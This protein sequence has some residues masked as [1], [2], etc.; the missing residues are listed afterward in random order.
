MLPPRKQWESNGEEHGPDGG[1]G[2][3][4]RG[5]GAGTSR[6]R[7]HRWQ[8]RRSRAPPGRRS[9]PRQM[10]PGSPG[11]CLGLPRHPRGLSA[12]SPAGG[13]PGSSGARAAAGPSRHW[14]LPLPRGLG[15]APVRFEGRALPRPAPTPG[16]EQR[17]DPRK[18]RAPRSL[19]RRPATVVPRGR[20]RRRRRPGGRERPRME[21]EIARDNNPGPARVGSLPAGRPVSGKFPR[22][23]LS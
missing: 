16:A 5:A 23:D 19:L 15:C 4:Q 6:R 12:P 18:T 11:G 7:C 9:L 13:V 10:L 17:P 2:C 8:G 3:R 21:K 14:H 1:S 20:A 22:S